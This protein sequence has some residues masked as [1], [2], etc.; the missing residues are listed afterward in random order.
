MSSY[1]QLVNRLKLELGVAG[2]ELSTVDNQTAMKKKLVDWVA[3]ADIHIQSMHW[4]WDFL[5]SEYSQALTIGSATPPVP[6]DLGV[7][8]EDTF[9]L[10]YAT[11]TNR[12]LNSRNYRDWYLTEG[13]GVKSNGK[14]FQVMVKPDNQLI[15]DNPPDAAYTLSGHYWKKP[16]K[17]TASADTSDIP[18]Q[19]ERIIIVQAK[20]WYGEEEEFPLVIEQAQK[21][22]GI[23]Q[24]SRAQ[25]GLMRQLESNQLPGQKNRNM[26]AGPDITV[27]PE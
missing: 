26:G 2:D 17:M 15:V 3:S 5:W 9:F 7:W 18:V 11:S 6:T 10:D 12:P 14:P 19:F 27:V 20:L 8:D 25:K 24:Y 13:M 21:E 16:T 22:L 1:L 23:E 4:D